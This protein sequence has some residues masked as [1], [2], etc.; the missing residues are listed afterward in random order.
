MNPYPLEFL[1]QSS[2]DLETSRMNV[3]SVHAT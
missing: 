1:V 2:I 3:A